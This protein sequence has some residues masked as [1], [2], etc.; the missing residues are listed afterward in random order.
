RDPM[1]QIFSLSSGAVPP[2]TSVVGFRGSE[3]LSTLYSFE[4][5][6]ALPA[7]DFDPA[8][9]VGSRAT[10]SLDRQ[11]GKPPFLFHGIFSEL[12]L[13][14][15]RGGRPLVRGLL[16]PKLWRLGQTLHSRVFTDMSLPDILA[17]TL[18]GGGLSGTDY[19]LRLSGAYPPEE[20][21]GQYQESDLDFL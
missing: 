6:L 10:L 19:A 5:H 20:H 9:A 18:E 14:H 12:S 17:A 8:R 13:V 1:A 4:I 11:D 21:V 7:D 3:G 16:V 2:G 15:E